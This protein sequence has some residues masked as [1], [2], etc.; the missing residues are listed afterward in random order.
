MGLHFPADIP[1][2]GQRGALAEKPVKIKRTAVLLCQVRPC[3]SDP[4][5]QPHKQGPRWREFKQAPLFSYLAL[6]VWNGWWTYLQHAGDNRQ[7]LYFADFGC[8]ALLFGLALGLKSFHY[9]SILL[10][11]EAHST[12]YCSVLLWLQDTLFF[13]LVLL[14]HA[15]LILLLF[16]IA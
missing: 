4:P 7:E 13:S 10:W 1:T 2:R 12:Y 3:S 8:H 6:F 9:Y 16:S 5:A 15:K 11:R 14:W